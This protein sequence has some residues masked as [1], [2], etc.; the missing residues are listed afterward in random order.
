MNF[1][2]KTKFLIAVIIVLSAIIIAI[3]GTVGY[4]YFRFEKAQS[5]K[6]QGK[7]QGARYMAKQLR[8]T[9]EQEIQIDTLRERFHRVADALEVSSRSISKEIMEELTSEN[10]DTVKLKALAEE[11]GKLQ[12]E[13]KQV[14]INHLLEVRSMC[15]FNQQKPFRKFIRQMEN[16]VGNVKREKNRKTGTS[17]RN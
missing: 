15:S 5:D 12:K 9:P 4:H 10:P 13:Q 8:L 6:P 11:F 17:Q 14:T 16:H 2:T 3:F 1:F 7:N